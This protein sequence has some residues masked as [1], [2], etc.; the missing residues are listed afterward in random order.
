MTD[1][2]PKTP[3]RCIACQK[4]I[5]ANEKKFEDDGF[6]YHFKCFTCDKCGDT[7]STGVYTEIDGERVCSKCRKLEVCHGC[8]FIITET[9]MEVDGKFWH[10]ECFV[11]ASCRA[12]LSTFFEKYHQFYC[13]D[14]VKHPESKSCCKCGRALRDPHKVVRELD[15]LWHRD[16][17]RCHYCNRDISDYYT[18]RRGFPYCRVCE[19]KTIPSKRQASNASH[20]LGNRLNL[21]SSGGVLNDQI[22][23]RGEGVV[24]PRGLNT[25]GGIPI[26]PHEPELDKGVVSPRKAIPLKKSPSL[27]PDQIKEGIDPKKKFVSESDRKE[28]PALW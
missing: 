15:K 11:C 28:R 5:A 4:E 12:P 26:S 17:F 14:C 2:P 16:C 20:A 18:E 6:L 23:P 7:L 25:S 27:V 10:K 9:S 3:E 1:K 13:A 8:G 24:S 19:R 21:S 22:S